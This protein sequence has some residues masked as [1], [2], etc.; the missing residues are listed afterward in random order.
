MLGKR[1]AA[2]VASCGAPG[3]AGPGV[4]RAGHGCAGGG[5]RQGP[6]PSVGAAELSLPRAEVG[7]GAVAGA[8]AP[9]VGF[10][11]ADR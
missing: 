8:A 9:A 6:V 7:Y 2:A 11:P 10:L 4:C 5:G 3:G 1:G